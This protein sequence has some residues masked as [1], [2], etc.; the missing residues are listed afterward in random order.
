MLAQSGCLVN[1]KIKIQSPATWKLNSYRQ[2]NTLSPT[3]P[4]L[5]LQKSSLK[6]L[7]LSFYQ[8]RWTHTKHLQLHGDTQRHYHDV[9]NLM[10]S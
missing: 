1:S 7:L 4:N 3:C 10:C 5:E 2:R 6:Q 9:E 8:D